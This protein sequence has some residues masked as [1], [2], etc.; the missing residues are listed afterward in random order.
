MTEPYR[1][2]FHTPARY[3]LP[4]KRHLYAFSAAIVLLGSFHLPS[5]GESTPAAAPLAPTKARP[6]SK[7]TYVTGDEKVWSDFPKCPVSGSE[8]DQTDLK[9]VLAL[10]ASRTPE[11]KAEAL[12]AKKMQITLVTD[13]ITPDFKTKYPKTF[14]LLELANEDVYFITTQIK[15]KNTRPRPYAQ[16]PDQVKP[17]YTTGGYSYPSGHASGVEFQARVLGTLFPAK[18]EELLKRARQVGESRV[19]AGVH[20]PSDVQAGYNLGDLLFQE[21]EANPQFKKDLAAAVRA[22]HLP[23]P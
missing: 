20:Y 9:G 8:A 2:A 7:P 1:V 5:S 3:S 23:T 22:D 16:H 12:A 17:L 15:D 10:Q 14:A 11:Q 13:T 6:A 18:S 4:M 21:L 19:V